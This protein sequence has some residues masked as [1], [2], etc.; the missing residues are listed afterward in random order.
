MGELQKK[1]EDLTA[2]E[3]EHLNEITTLKTALTQR[4][5]YSRDFVQF[6]TMHISRCVH[7]YLQ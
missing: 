4:Q 7:S 5:V 2:V 3:K 6:L 1:I